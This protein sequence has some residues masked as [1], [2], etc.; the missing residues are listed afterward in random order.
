MPTPR[1]SFTN[2]QSASN[3]MPRQ[4]NRN[5]IFNQIRTRQPISRR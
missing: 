1:Y 5:L 3:K 4:I 2:K